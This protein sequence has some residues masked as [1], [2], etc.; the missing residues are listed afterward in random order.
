MRKLPTFIATLLLALNAAAFDSDPFAGMLFWHASEQTAASWANATTTSENKLT[1]KNDNFRWD[2]GFRGGVTLKPASFFDAKL[3]WT[4]FTNESN[5]RIPTGVHVVVPEYFSG[6]ISGNF[7]FGARQKWRIRMNT[8]DFEMSHPFNLT[9]DFTLS[10]VVGIKAAIVKQN[11]DTLWQAEIYNSTEK[12]KSTYLGAGPTFGLSGTWNFAKPFT[13]VTDITTTFLAG[14]WD[15]SDVYKRPY[16]PLSL[17]PNATTIKTTLHDSDLGTL[18]VRYFVG[19]RWSPPEYK[20]IRVEVGY[21]LQYWANQL[22][23]VTFQQL[24]THGDLTLQGGTCSFSLD[25]Y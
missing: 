6:F 20:R 13:F 22:R 10:P 21:D 24:P 7:F 17:T 8:L 2:P 16:V 12:V 14:V 9:H 15:V 11:I 25:L 4:S 19:M 1:F 23:L 5:D 18:M 3:Y